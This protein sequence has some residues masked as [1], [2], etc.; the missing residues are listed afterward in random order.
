MILPKSIKPFLY[1]SRTTLIN[2]FQLNHRW[3]YFIN[4]HQLLNHGFKWKNILFN[5]YDIYL[6]LQWKVLPI[7]WIHSEFI[8]YLQ[9]LKI[10]LYI[11]SLLIILNFL[12]Q[13]NIFFIEFGIKL[14][15]DIID[16]FFDYHVGHHV[17]HEVFLNVILF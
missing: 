15:H 12:Q 17:F 7:F 11:K 3:L 13:L 14:I 4:L 9:R 8:V 2:M 16:I 5:M 10:K 1:L 6:W